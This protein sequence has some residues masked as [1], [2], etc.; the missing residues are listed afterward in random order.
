MLGTPPI[1]LQNDYSIINRRIEENGVSEAS[2]PVHENV[3]FMAYNSLA[4]GVLTGKYL[5]EPAAV[6]DTSMLDWGLDVCICKLWTAYSRLCQ[7]RFLRSTPHFSAFFEFYI[8][9]RGASEGI[10]KHCFLC[11][12]PDFSDLSWFKTFEQFL[13]NL[14]TQFSLNFKRQQILQFFNCFC[15]K[16]TE[17]LQSFTELQ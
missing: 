15:Q 11:T 8:F 5:K 9:A 2:S 13:Q 14:T 16:L 7:Y 4:G 10:R 17:F 6:D 3:G 12:I 1:V